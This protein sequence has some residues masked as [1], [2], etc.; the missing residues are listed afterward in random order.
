[1]A[2]S[3]EP[4]LE[5]RNSRN[6]TKGENQGCAWTSQAGAAFSNPF[7]SQFAQDSENTSPTRSSSGPA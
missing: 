1:M 3:G 7:T 2:H 4:K 6:D 5:P